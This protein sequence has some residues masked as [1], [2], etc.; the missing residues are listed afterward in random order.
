MVPFVRERFH[1]R[2]RARCNEPGRLADARS[3]NAATFV[4]TEPQWVWIPALRL[5]EMMV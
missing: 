4:S 2:R 1:V 3:D 5:L